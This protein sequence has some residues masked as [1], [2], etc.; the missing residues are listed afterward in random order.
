MT[1]PTSTLEMKDFKVGDKV[2]VIC[3]F[4]DFHFGWQGLKGYIKKKEDRNILVVFSEPVTMY[5]DICSEF[6]FYPHDL[7]KL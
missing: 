4:R 5:G 1:N 7:V 6:H 3:K 2:K